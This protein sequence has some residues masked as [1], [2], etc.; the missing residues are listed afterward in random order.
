MAKPSTRPPSR[1]AP[2]LTLL[3]CAVL[4]V[5]SCQAA[6]READ[7]ED[8]AQA[9][10]DQPMVSIATGSNQLLRRAPAVATVITAQD[11]Q[12]MGA[13]DLDE[14]MESIAGVHVSRSTQGYQP[15][16]VIRGVNLGFNPQVLML[17]N[18]IPI[19]SIFA[20]NRGFIWGGFPLD[21][22]ARIEIIRGPG[23]ALYGA[24]A[25]AGVINVITKSAE[26]GNG[27]TAGVR[28]GSFKAYDA[29]T[30]HGGKWGPFGVAA[31]LRRGATDGAK[32]IVQA[33]AQTG[34]D[35]QA[36]THASLAPGPISNGRDFIDGS[37]DLNLDK[38]RWRFGIR[39]RDNVGSSVGVASALDPTG[40]NRSQM[41]T[42]DLNYDN[43]SIASDWALNAQISAMHYSERSDLV[44]YPPGSVFGGSAYTDGMIG[45]PHKW[46]RH[47]RISAAATYSGLDRH[48]VRIG[49]GAQSSALYKIRQTRN[50]N[51]NFTPI[52]TGSIAD[53]EDV[54]QTR[55]FLRPHSRQ[56]RYVY[57]QDEWNLAPDWTLTSGLR[58]DAYSDF[59]GTTN[60]RL[61]LV[62]DTAYNV[63]TKLMA[64]SAFRAPSFTEL[65]A[66][67]NPVVQG[68]AALKPEKSRTIEAAV[69]WQ[70]TPQW[71]VSANAFHYKM[72]N[73][74]QLVNF[75]YQNTGQLSGNGLELETSWTI[76]NTLRLS[77]NYSFQYSIDDARH[78]DAGNA[79]HHQA[80]ARVDWRVQPNWS[81]HA[82][83]NWV[84]D[85]TRVYNDTRPSLAGYNTV[86]LTL[87]SEY[88][89]KGWNTAISVRNLL[90]SDVREP[91]TYDY[92]SAGHP[93]I[94]LPYDFPMPGRSIYVQGTYA[95]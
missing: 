87:R 59:G 79:P 58:H 65:Y 51:N 50:S 22:V 62:W 2:A 16:Y 27:T 41:L 5:A 70:A 32:S 43:D 31:Y 46:E 19:T 53:V 89:G 36:G 61:A 37:L 63:T 82:Q 48:R 25:M 83:I 45:T 49:V 17:I 94:S 75:V 77:G 47:H 26:D 11:I 10:G 92:N 12:A 68:N 42:S 90:D 13:T 1:T 60:P 95:F 24:D 40:Y 15:L 23:S 88:E 54:S 57:G 56:S 30:L 7:E 29:W 78:H 28:T 69:S 4:G 81:A 55:P 20:G 73:I 39:D 6:A 93:F 35:A 33:D 8:L 14:V 76:S 86:D 71:Q 3:T 85:Q 84:N 52:G 67:N 38:W 44:L 64:G 18:G 21:N 9:Y 34:R 80:Y 74:I 66:V 91:T 72:D